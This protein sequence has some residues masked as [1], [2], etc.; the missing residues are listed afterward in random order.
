MKRE[1]LSTNAEGENMLGEEEG[2]QSI[3]S[4]VSKGLRTWE[5][6]PITI[7]PKSWASGSHVELSRSSILSP[8]HSAPI[9]LWTIV[10]SVSLSV[11][12]DL[13]PSSE[14]RTRSG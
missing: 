12:F 5:I 9:F 10:P 13:S 7:L 3:Q 6:Y 4:W 14:A 1:K 8:G 2:G 11:T